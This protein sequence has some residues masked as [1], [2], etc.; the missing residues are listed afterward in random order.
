MTVSAVIVVVVI[1]LSRQELFRAKGFAVVVVVSV[2]TSS[3]PTSTL[4]PTDSDV[5]GMVVVGNALTT[6]TP[7]HERSVASS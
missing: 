4:M 3:P 5:D 1:L 6:L 7:N 2:K